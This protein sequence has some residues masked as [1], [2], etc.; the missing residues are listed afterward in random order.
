MFLEFEFRYTL[1]TEKPGQNPILQRKIHGITKDLND[2]L[3]QNPSKW[4]IE[5]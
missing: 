5:Q 4:K 1:K 3:V 2:L